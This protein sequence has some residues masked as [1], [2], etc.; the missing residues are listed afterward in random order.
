MNIKAR[1]TGIVATCDCGTKLYIP[2]ESAIKTQHLCCP[3]GHIESIEKD[4]INKIQTRVIRA[5][6]ARQGLWK[7]KAKAVNLSTSV[8]KRI[9]HD[10]QSIG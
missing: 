1:Q 3:C 4:V 6:L 2:S 8:F 10:F 7:P 9:S 5:H